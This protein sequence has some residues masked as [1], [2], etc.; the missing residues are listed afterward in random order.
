MTP[1]SPGART[2][3]ATTAGRWARL[4][5]DLGHRVEVRGRYD[6]QPADLLV[7][8]HARRSADSVERFAATRPGRPVV[9]ALT[10]TDL[11]HDIHHDPAAARTLERATA[12]VVLQALGLDQL[13]D[14]LRQRTWIIHQSALAPPAVPAPLARC[15]EVCVSANLRPVKDPLRA[16]EA[17][18][19]LPADSR[20]V[21]SHLG[22]ALDDDLEAAARAEMATNPRYRWLGGR[23]PRQALRLMGRSRLL[24]L[25]SWSEGGANVV[26]E[27]IALGVPVVSSHIAGSIGILGE[28]HPGYFTPGDTE[29]LATLLA[30]AERQPA[31]LEELRQRS[32]RLRPLVDPQRE[33]GEWARLLAAV[34][35]TPGPAPAPAPAS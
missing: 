7:A 17:A 14:R 13:P 6:G 5:R 24:V 8:L 29:E 11:Y 15:F 10:G 16:A 30:R 12:F 3:N 20:L 26:S 27:A 4:L 32:L 22:H 2:G 18:R 31:W 21:V 35:A 28:D 25:S 19:L 34:T 23:P 9:V 33:R 1:V